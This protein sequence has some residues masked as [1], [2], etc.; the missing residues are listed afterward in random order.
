MVPVP[1]ARRLFPV[2]ATLLAFI[3]IGGIG[4]NGLPA[5]ADT[6]T[7]TTVPFVLLPGATT[8]TTA[9]APAPGD[10]TTT[11]PGGTTQQG[12]STTTTTKKPSSGVPNV[13][14][15]G[16]AT[17]TTTVKPGAKPPPPAPQPDPT[18][19][20]AQVDTDLAQLTAIGD[21]QPAQGLVAKAQSQITEAGAA[22]LSARHNLESAQAARAEAAAFKSNADEKLKQ[23]AIAAYVGIGYSTPGLGEPVGG[24][25]F[26]GPSD[27]TAPGGLTG[28]DSVDAR[29]MMII[30]GAHVRESAN[31][32]GHVYA[33]ATRAA[34]A[35]AAAYAAQRAAVGTA[36]AKLL[37]A[38][39]T[40]KI[41]TTAAITPG[42][43][44]A[45]PID[46]LMSAAGAPPAAGP[47]PPAAAATAA[48]TTTTTSTTTT[49]TTTVPG[50]PAVPLTIPATINGAP[51][52]SPT[53]LGTPVVDQA[54]LQ[55]W[56]AT[57]NRKPNITVPINQLIGSYASWGQKL[58]IRYDVAFAQSIVE[59]GYFSFP[60][61]GQLTPKDNNFAGIGACDTCAH[62]WTFPSA[63]TGV[64]AQLELLH[65]YATSTPWPKDIPNVIH[66]TSVGGC[67]QT[68]SQLAGTW[69]S[70]TVYGIS[71]MTVYQQMLQWLIPQ[72]ELAAGLIAPTAPAVKG[73][74]LAPLPGSSTTTTVPAQAQQNQKAARPQNVAAATRG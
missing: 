12:A 10:T 70:S 22:L 16:P 13:P 41:I 3:L 47:H 11:A 4:A 60:A 54:H 74:E 39:Q 55:A 7:T 63:D 59:T 28:L 52:T 25:G 73:P 48:T 67:C 23:L 64:Q 53:I 65:L 36:E 1:A 24:N 31:N 43:A 37:T 32:A 29:E 9:P 35:A 27:I 51:P 68:W 42:A 40:L 50:Q 18:P 8:T 45:T 66:G 58:G 21:Y 5:A 61:F 56:W 6:G 15:G 46:Q 26:Q 44:A 30:V 19:I 62:G 38:Q 71:I 69:A 49:T 72:Q 34:H 14:V 2:T 33:T 20:L 17:T 57:L